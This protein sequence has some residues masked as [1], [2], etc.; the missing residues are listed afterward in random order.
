MYIAVA[1]PHS[2]TP[3]TVSATRAASASGRSSSHSV[4]SAAKPTTNALEIVPMPGVSRSGI[5]KTRTTKLITTTAWPSV[6]GTCWI[7]PEC[8][9]SQ[10]ASPRS[11]R[12][13]IASEAP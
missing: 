1:S 5:Q 12:T 4:P 10:G 11:P 8:R 2:A 3:P 13:I 9:T 6:I 7:R